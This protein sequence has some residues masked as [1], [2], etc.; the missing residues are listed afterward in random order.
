MEN[1]KK[2]LPNETDEIFLTDG[3]LET[4]LVFLEGFDLPYFAAFDLLK[5]KEGY[6]ALKNYYTRYLKIAKK[7][8]TNFILETPTWRTNP[9]WIE[10]IGH[11]RN[12][13][14]A[15]N[16]KAVTLLAD[17][18]TEFEN[19]INSILIS[20]CIGPRGDGYVPE[21][22]MRIEEA[23]QYHT[24]QIEAFSHTSIDFVSA[25]TMN[26]IEEV[27]GIVKAAES[28]NLP[29]V[30]SFTVETNGKL[31]TGMSLKDAIEKADQS[32]NVPPI[33]YMI[34]CAHPTHF[35][36]ELNASKNEN[37]VKRIKAIRANA[38]CKSHA[39]LDEAIEL[40]RGVP[41]ELGKEYKVLKDSFPHLN[42]FGGCCG[43][44]EEHIIEIADQLKNNVN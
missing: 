28:F 27:I 18:K 23:R 8:Q 7:Y 41:K 42:V 14:A 37:W 40:D 11:H 6:N 32:V 35:L 25:I 30:I 17:L 22:C 1:N 15:L 16:E 29:V 20:G 44:D 38:S 5:N 3:G 10:K 36:N 21:N 31:P 12:E 13:L 4:T 2:T 24:A 43:T 19:D 39:E 9:D 34:N 26:Y 33:Y